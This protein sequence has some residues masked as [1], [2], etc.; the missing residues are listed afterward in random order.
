M[1]LDS[2]LD[3]YEAA[4]KDAAAARQAE[5]QAEQ[6]RLL[7]NAAHITRTLR[8]IVDPVLTTAAQQLRAREFHAAITYTRKK[9]LHGTPAEIDA[10]LTLSFTTQDKDPS[11]ASG[12]ISYAGSE[13]TATLSIHRIVNRT[14]GPKDGPIPYH[15]LTS[16]MVDTQLQQLLSSIFKA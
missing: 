15:D 16:E 7:A 14:N 13:Q 10:E 5:A 8:N 4:Q 2:I 9:L 3:A 12:S 1:N 6:Q 11:G